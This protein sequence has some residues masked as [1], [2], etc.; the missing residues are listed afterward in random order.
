M[1]DLLGRERRGQAAGVRLVGAPI[2]SCNYV[3]W[4]LPAPSKPQK[5][6]HRAGVARQLGQ[7]EGRTI[8]TGKVEGSRLRPFLRRRMRIQNAD[9]FLV[10]NAASSASR[11]TTSP[12]GISEG[13]EDTDR[14]LAEQL[15]DL[16]VQCFCGRLSRGGDRRARLNDHRS[17]GACRR[18]RE[19]VEVNATARTLATTLPSPG[20]G[21]QPGRAMPRAPI[22][23][24]NG[25]AH[26]ACAVGVGILLP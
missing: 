12:G 14:A 18:L 9:R 15:F 26:L 6:R 5:A 11:S 24:A 3:K 19:E 7:G 10:D 1:V 16:D 21:R 4:K 20:R 23:D 8:A 2:T 25:C 17:R 13:L 22:H